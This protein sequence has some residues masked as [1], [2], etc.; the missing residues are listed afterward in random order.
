MLIVWGMMNVRKEG[1]E[2][3]EVT[4]PSV[5]VPDVDIEP[6]EVPVPMSKPVIQE[7]PNRMSRVLGMDMNMAD[8]MESGSYKSCGCSDGSRIVIMN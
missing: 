5:A 3:M 6:V 4:E 1:M 2:G 8:A 7:P